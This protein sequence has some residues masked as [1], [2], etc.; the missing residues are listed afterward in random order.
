MQTWSWLKLILETTKKKYLANVK[1]IIYS[2][3]GHNLELQTNEERATCK[4]HVSKYIK[5]T[6]NDPKGRKKKLPIRASRLS[7]QRIPGADNLP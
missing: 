2:K 6:P 7:W 3:F 1:D 4:K 5:M